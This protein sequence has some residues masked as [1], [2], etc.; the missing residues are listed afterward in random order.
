MKVLEIIKDKFAL[1]V[2]W[3]NLTVIQL[4][5]KSIIV[6]VYIVLKVFRGSFAGISYLL[7]KNPSIVI[8]IAIIIIIITL[9]I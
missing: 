7:K 5:I 6:I 4:I 2:E 1:F 8:W 3:F 9:L